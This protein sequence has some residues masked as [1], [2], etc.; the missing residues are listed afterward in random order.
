MPVTILDPHSAL[1]V[2]DLQKGLA[3]L[4]PAPIWDGVVARSRELVAAFR[5][6][7][8]P[9]VI[10]TADGGAPGRT[11]LSRHFDVPPG[12]ADPLDGLAHPDDLFVVKQTWGAFTH[13]DLAARLK[14]LGITQVVV[15]G[16]AT[17]IG[18]ESTARQA[19]EAGFNVTIAT[20][21]VADLTEENHA[22]SLARIFPR[23][24]ET[25]PAR[26]IIA[27]LA[28]DPHA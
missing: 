28:D 20:D 6:H 15:I 21:A 13:G 12:F 27:L 11:E 18:V 7:G 23:L 3:G 19:Y 16:V 17:S 4:L 9:V 24:G 22:H 8:R 5:S 1:I 25:G 26:D 10:V 14:A 2:V